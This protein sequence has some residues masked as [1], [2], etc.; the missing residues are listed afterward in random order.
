MLKA[1]AVGDK[2]TFRAERIEGR[3]TLTYIERRK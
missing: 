3:I 1:V 2:V